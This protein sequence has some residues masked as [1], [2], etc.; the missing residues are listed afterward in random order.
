MTT[1]VALVDVVTKG[2]AMRTTITLGNDDMGQLVA[3]AD[4]DGVCNRDKFN[5]VGTNVK[6]GKP[7]LAH[8]VVSVGD[9]NEYLQWGCKD[10][11]R[12]GLTVT[13]TA[14]NAEPPTSVTA[15]VTRSLTV[16]CC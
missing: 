10:G 7:N 1:L 9:N 13:N 2:D 15:K 12:T 4:N 5:T 16:T 8:V 11:R 6:V 14:S 3:K